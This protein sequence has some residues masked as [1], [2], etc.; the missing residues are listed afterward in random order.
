MALRD[1]SLMLLVCLLW[2]AHTIV[3]K[4]V[5]SG[6]EIPPL[7]YAAIRYGIVAALALPWLLPAPKAMGRVLL[8]AFLMGGG[9]FAL[10][11]LGIKTASPSSAAIVT[12][13]GLPITALLSFAMLGERITWRRGIGI[14]LTFTGGVLVMWDPRSDV[15]ISGGLVLVLGS[16]AAGSLAAVM[17]KQVKGVRPLQFQAWVGIAS[18]VPLAFLTTG[19]ETNQ[20]DYA[21]QAGWAFVAAVL[22]SALVVSMLAHTIYYGL[23]AKYPANLIAPLT[24]MNPLLTVALGISITGDEFDARM[25]LGT[26]IALCGILIITLRRNHMVPQA[27]LAWRHARKP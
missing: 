6:M 13:L 11:F 9:G 21:M 3:S 4:I 26:G 20:I 7:F 22:F 8:V 12:Q 17:M 24:I 19:V 5:V 25:A 10:F 15:P 1:F 16:A 27:L 14:A 18:V 2:A 23:I